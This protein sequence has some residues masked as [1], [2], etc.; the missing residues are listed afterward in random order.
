[1]SSME[2]SKPD[3]GAVRRSSYLTFRCTW[4]PQLLISGQVATGVAW[5]FGC[6]AR[7][8]LAIAARGSAALDVG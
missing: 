4:D 5:F 8:K 3:K 2:E 7:V 6:N 1:M